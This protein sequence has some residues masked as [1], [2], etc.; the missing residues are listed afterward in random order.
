MKCVVCRVGQTQPGKTAVTLE[1]GNM[2][3]VFKNV[4]AEV[5]ENCGE[6]YISDEISRHVLQAAE[7]VARAG[8]QV[9]VREFVATPV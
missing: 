2:T 6:A 8:V 5:C 4:P 3:L 9:D 1:R 7:E